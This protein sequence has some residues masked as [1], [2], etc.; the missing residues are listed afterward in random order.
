MRQAS[1]LEAAWK[2]SL[3]RGN[4]T[5]GAGTALKAVSVC[6]CCYLGSRFEPVDPQ[7]RTAILFPPYAVLTAALLFSPA[8]DWWIYLLAS[9][10][11]NYL[12]HRQSAPA[13]WVIL[14]EIANFTR[15]ML[16]AGGIRYLMPNGPRFDNLRGVVTF[17]SYAVVVGPFAAAFIGAGVVVLHGGAHDF[18][19]VWQAWYLSNALTGLTLLPI[20]VIGVGDALLWFRRFNWRR[21]LEVICLLV[22][23]LSV[24]M[25]V[26]AGQYTG[27]SS[28][29]ARLYAPLPFF[30][31]A[32]VRFGPGATSAAVLVVTVLAIWGILHEHGPFVTQSP[33][34]NMLSLQLFL[35]TISVPLLVLAALMAE[36][37]QEMTE[38]RQREQALHSS[39]SQIKELTGRLITAQETERARIARQLHDDI[40]QQLA[41]MCIALSNLKR[42]F[43]QKSQKI[44]SDVV[45]L[46]QQAMS[47]SDE[48][49]NLSHEL[50]P[51]VLRHAGLVV[52]L[53]G[54]CAELGRMHG[55]E[56][57][58]EAEDNL[59]GLPFDIALCLYRVAQ[60]ALH[61]TIIHARARHIRIALSRNPAGLEL[62]VSDDGCGFDLV[63]ANRALGLGLVSVEERV[64]LIQGTLRIESRPQ[65]GTELRVQVPMRAVGG[66]GFESVCA[67]ARREAAKNEP[68]VDFTPTH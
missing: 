27:E 28:L 19:L 42:R 26:F 24:G 15:A 36:R 22:G 46:Q 18:W 38:R 62:S 23:L 66:E 10:L 35:L 47:L 32:A 63:E 21:S 60:E 44:H 54:S 29:P 45:R 57:S 58:V 43:P 53:Q 49:R 4:E 67:A 65:W 1:R 34:D 5:H 20:M 13:S 2:W 11:G 17:L 31:W 39:Y 25:L 33:A 16:A 51:G 8:R 68:V 9:A 56:M 12:P 30:L 61:N 59:E 64:R 14:T 40:N 55:I 50:H 41:A 52:A 7:L 6:I 48:I 37:H 3:L